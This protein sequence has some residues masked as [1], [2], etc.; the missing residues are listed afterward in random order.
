MVYCLVSE[1]AKCFFFYFTFSF[2]SYFSLSSSVCV[3][4]FHFLFSFFL[5]TTRIFLR[6]HHLNS[7]MHLHGKPI[8]KR[9]C[10]FAKGKN[11]KEWRRKKRALTDRLQLNR[12]ENMN[13]I[14]A[15][16]LKDVL[17]DHYDQTCTKLMFSFRYFA[18]S[19]RKYSPT[20]W[21]LSLCL[22][23]SLYW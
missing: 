1:S 17:Y 19:Q 3:W 18:F 8:Y 6:V 16:A 20:D 22:F 23:R 11:E 5:F 13:G 4:F 12:M 10:C 7:F 9:F 21:F 14:N 15:V 2:R